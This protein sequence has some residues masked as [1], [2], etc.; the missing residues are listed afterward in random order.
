M[1][2]PRS[3]VR[4]TL[5]AIAAFVL[6]A[7]F[8]AGAHVTRSFDHTW[9]KHI[10]PKTD[11]RYPK[12]AALSDPGVLNDAGNPV[13]WTKLKN[14]PP[15]L[16]GDLATQAE[17]DTHKASDDHDD[18]YYTQEQLSDSDGDNPNLGSNRVHWDNLGGVP[19]DIADGDDA[20][21]PAWLLAGN[22]GTNPATDFVGTTDAQPLIFKANGQQAL[23]LEA[24][25]DPN[26]I[27]GFHGN[28]V[29]DG[30]QGATIGG[31]GS[32]LPGPTPNTVTDDYGAIGG[33]RGNRA[34][35]AVGTTADAAYATVGGGLSNIAS[36]SSSTIAGGGSNLASGSLAT[37]G[38]GNAHNASGAN[39]TIAGG[40]DHDAT[41][42]NA[43]IGGGANNDAT[44]DSTT[45]AGGE[46]N[47]ASGFRATV[48]G[49][50][51][52]TASGLDSVVGG[53]GFN[54]ASGE[55][56]T[57]GGGNNNSASMAYATVGGGRFNEAAAQYSTIGGGAPSDFGDI[58][59]TKNVVTDDYG[60]VG[61]GGNNQAGNA[62]GTTSDA[63]YSTVGGGLS[64]TAGGIQATVA[65][66]QGNT[67]GG[68]VDTV[69]GGDSNTATSAA[70]G[71]T[72]GG[73]GSNSA[74]GTAATIPGGV[75]N[76]AAGDF[77]FASGRRAKIDAAHDGS[78][79]FADSTDADFASAAANEFAVRASGGSRVYT[80]SDLSSGVFL[81]PGGGAWQTVS[82]RSVKE[83]VE[84]IDGRTVLQGVAGLPI[85]TW[86]YETQ[87]EWIRHMGPM[88]Q[89]F[90]T[91]FG[92]GSNERTIGT[93]DA[94]G[95]ALAAIQG[96]NTVVEEQETHIVA[97]EERIVALE[98]GAP[99]SQAG[100][101][102]GI[103]FALIGALSTLVLGLGVLLVRNKNA[104]R[105][106]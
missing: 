63:N 70:G 97:L 64:N 12:K 104:G 43:S 100:G 33:G 44:S 24:S 8:P 6:M 78:F 17:L 14:V 92:L 37:I 5:A 51:Q 45:V 79:L 71:A 19:P 15:E 77:A 82:D 73:G 67:A 93:V 61:G 89:D 58:G 36:G 47:T 22:A 32:N 38:G 99:P 55:S 40:F 66:G 10:R 80:S 18:A 16:G 23:R 86:N 87:D 31:G 1:S 4:I 52:N 7:A 49:G 88:A 34:G 85:A 9:K 30:A 72:V 68:S 62:A 48:A 29:T 106:V 56:A 96:L 101:I 59:N 83:N 46:F 54:G 94:D 98:S 103:L 60:T 42:P 35:D 27:G 3:P 102:S 39:A 76:A 90:R 50:R 65:G 28:D 105:I 69:A 21:Q 84:P 75:N 74:T 81:D 2:H 41:G 53:G 95:V 57:V 13:D 20:G 11:G 25:S 26:V 91:A